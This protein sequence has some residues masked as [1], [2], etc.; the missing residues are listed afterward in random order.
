MT[1]YMEQGMVQTWSSAADLSVSSVEKGWAVIMTL[2]LLFVLIVVLAYLAHRADAKAKSITPLTDV[3]T[4]ASWTLKARSPNRDLN[5]TPLVGLK[6][7]QP[8]KIRKVV[9]ESEISTIEKSLPEVL[10]S[11]P[12]GER[13]KDEIMHYHRW[14]GIIFYY[15][16]VFP[17]VL[18]ITFLA[19]NIISML[20]VQAITYRLTNPDDG[21]CEAI[22]TEGACLLPRSPFSSDEPK[23]FWLHG[24][25]R[26]SCHFSEPENS[27]KVV[28][29]VAVLAAIV[30]TPITLS[31]EWIMMNVLAASTT[32]YHRGA[33][34]TDMVAT[35]ERRANTELVSMSTVSASQ[36]LDQLAV[37]LQGYRSSLNAIQRREFDG[38][39]LYMYLHLY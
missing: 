38:T 21:S 31:V 20:F 8:K 17:R 16:P 19:S 10:R 34:S 25:R 3:L 11:K 2:G 5:F 23:C 39:I 12:F 36:Y 13:L 37:Q 4:R 29:F 14:M 27:F 6:A 22:K 26:G 33:V 24:F 9:M 18:R 32:P 1:Q 7:N 35:R 15:S 30:S 28:V